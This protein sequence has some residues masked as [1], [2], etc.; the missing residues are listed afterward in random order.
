MG[1]SLTPKERMAIPRQP[2]PEQPPEVRRHNFDEVP[3]GYT[4]ELAIREA[5]RCLQCKKPACVDGC[6]VN[7]AIPQFIEKIVERD[8]EG[9]LQIILGTNSLPAICGRVCPQE[10]QCE[11]YCVLA[12]RGDPV[13]IGRL[14]RFVADHVRIRLMRGEKAPLPPTAPPPG[15]PKVAI[16]GSGPAGLTCAADLLNAGYNVTLFEALH[17]PG[18]VLVYGIPEFRLPKAIVKAEIQALVRRGLQ[19]VT[20]AVIGRLYTIDDLLNEEGYAAVFIGTGAGTPKFLKIPGENLNGVYSANEFLTRVNLMKAYLP[21]AETPIVRGK[22]VAVFGA[23]N[24]AMDAAR[25]ALRIGAEE[26]YIMYRRSRAEMPARAEEIHHAE[27][28]GVKFE[29]LVNPVAF[30]GNERG[31]LQSVRC[32]RMQLGEPDDSGRR[33]PVRIAGSEFDTPINVA[34]VAVGTESNP[35]IRQTTPDLQ[36]NQWGYIVTDDM[37]RTSKPRVYAGGDIVTG[38][39]TVI[40]AMGAGKRAARAIISDLQGKG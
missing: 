6:P 31:W 5:Q 18:G 39:A 30:Y 21:D 12:K 25:T 19:I 1:T 27:E 22:R 10:T 8:F 15:A 16:V 9:A 33:R 40:E 34:I 26:V 37:G 36:V 20:N 7:V 32:E 35:L 17:E 24:T 29:F 2:M 38:A 13:A 23:G 14:E 4:E 28:E 11:K 3:L